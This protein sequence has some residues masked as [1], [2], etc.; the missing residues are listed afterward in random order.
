MKFDNQKEFYDYLVQ[1]SDAYYITNTPIISDNEF[2]KLVKEY[3]EEYG[4]FTYLG[5]SGKDTLPVY[6]ASLN[7]I[8]D[9]N[10][11]ENYK[12]KIKSD[13]VIITD[14]IDGISMLVKINKKGNISLYTRGNGYEGSNIS[15]I[16]DYINYGSVEFPS[17]KE[18]QIITE[19]ILIRGEIV[20]LKSTFEKHKNSFA[21]PRNMVAGIINS[22]VKDVSLL[23]DLTFIA[24]SLITDIPEIKTYEKSLRLLKRFGFNIPNYCVADKNAVNKTM[25]TELLAKQKSSVDYE[26]DGLVLNDNSLHKEK[27]GENPKFSVAFKVNTEFCEAVVEFVEWNIS[28]NNVIKP[29]IK[30]NPVQLNGVTINYVTGFNAK[31]IEDNNIGKGT[32]LSITRSGDVIPKI[33]KI[34]KSTEAQ[35]PDIDYIWNETYV[36]IITTDKNGKEQWVKKI[37]YMFSILDIKGIKEGVLLKLY[38]A[39]VD[40]DEKLFSLKKVP[41]AEGFKDKSSVNILKAID[42]LKTDMT[43]QKLMSGCCIFTNFGE[44]KIEKILDKIPYVK[45]SIIENKKINKE[46]LLKDLNNNGFHKTAKQF[47]D[48]LDIF[49]EYYNSVSKF[50]FK[51]TIVFE[52]NEEKSSTEDIGSSTIK[53]EKYEIVFEE[54]INSGLQELSSGSVIK[55]VFSGFRDKNLKQ[56][57]EK[58]NYKVVDTIS[59]QVNYLVVGDLSSTSTKV[60]KAE[61]Y[62]IK[63]ID[64]N[65]FRKML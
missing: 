12:N 29:R 7:K 32:I 14:K 26:I 42:Q 58:K 21:N 23:K 62:G 39:G 37:S 24:Y 40:T 9:D 52:E 60:Q 13:K 35:M 49:I 27:E 11:I 45:T 44:R 55:V 51:P 15:S 65:N 47:I 43:F 3:E 53:K 28:K 56:Q 36:D 5:P 4:N 48:A 10:S 25:L 2:D 50:F 1:A 8:K 17:L 34:I 16:K 20:M 19:D 6:M 64:I 54:E 46:I 63:I 22:K 38:E 61:E 30:I 33:E 59:K 41:T 18:N 31:Y 57:A